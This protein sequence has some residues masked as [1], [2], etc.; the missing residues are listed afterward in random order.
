MRVYGVPEEVLTDNGKVFTGRFHKPGIAVEVL[1][2]KI[3]RENGIAHRLTK[4][5]S[6]TTTGKTSQELDCQAASF[7]RWDQAAASL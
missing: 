6:P 2:D 3:C 5:H 1:F 7:P 4:I